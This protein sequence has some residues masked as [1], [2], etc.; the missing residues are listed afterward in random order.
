MKGYIQIL[1]NLGNMNFI[2]HCDLAP[3]AS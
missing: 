3:K 2:I 1:T